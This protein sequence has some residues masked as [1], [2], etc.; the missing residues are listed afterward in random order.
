[1][2]LQSHVFDDQPFRQPKSFNEKENACRALFDAV[3]SSGQTFWHVCTPGTIQSVIF[4][5]PEEYRFVVNA[6]AVSA[7]D[8]GVRI[9]TFEIMSNHV[10]IIVLC[11]DKAAA[12]GTTKP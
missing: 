11:E 6:V 4:R 3:I 12:S 5:S 10:H 7:H 9:I 8:A 2:K 1:M